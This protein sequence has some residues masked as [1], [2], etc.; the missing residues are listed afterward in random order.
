[1]AERTA[2]RIFQWLGRRCAA[3]RFRAGGQQRERLLRKVGCAM[4]AAAGH[5]LPCGAWKAHGEVAY[6][7][8]K[9]EP[10]GVP[11]EIRPLCRR[12]EVLE[13]YLSR[14]AR[15]FASEAAATPPRPQPAFVGPVPGTVFGLSR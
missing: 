4:G 3:Y 13:I 11:V 10:A 15:R 6:R 8:F 5:R 7:R 1:M 9:W 14:L 2:N 12:L